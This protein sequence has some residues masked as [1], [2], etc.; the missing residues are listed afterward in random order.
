[1]ATIKPMRLMK[2]IDWIWTGQTLS[3]AI[4]VMVMRE[5]MII[6]MIEPIAKIARTPRASGDL[7][8]YLSMM[9]PRL[10]SRQIELAIP[11]TSLLNPKSK[12]TGNAIRVPRFPKSWRSKAGPA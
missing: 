6:P 3:R 4:P 5:M 1:M 2:M 12:A 9:V 8:P 10:G 11:I 7:K